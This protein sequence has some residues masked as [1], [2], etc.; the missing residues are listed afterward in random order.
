M[1][2]FEQIVKPSGKF[3]Q[4]D[5]TEIRPT[6][7]I[8]VPLVVIV[9]I[10]L[11]ILFNLVIYPLKLF[12]GIYYATNGFITPTMLAYTLLYL[13]IVIFLILFLAKQK[14]R[15]IGIKKGKIIEGMVVT[16]TIW[17]II[18]IAGLIYSLIAFGSLVFH[19]SLAESGLVLIFTRN[20]EQL[21]FNGPFEELVYRAFLINQVY[22]WYK[23]K[24]ENKSK[25][26]KV[27]EDKPTLN[28]S[29]ISI[30]LPLVFS[31]IV[32]QI[33]FSLMHIPNRIMYVISQESYTSQDILWAAINPVGYG[34]LFIAGL[35]FALIYHRTDN[36]FIASGI[37]ALINYTTLLFDMSWINHLVLWTLI[38]LIVLFYPFLQVKLAVQSIKLKNSSN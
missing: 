24:S 33:I 29:S 30:H 6:K 21:V 27:P 32:T 9:N 5:F 23:L 14:A 37:H 17:A 26:S 22:L 1:N 12:N 10:L 4:F 7:I 20:I 28:V 11:A 3:L 2:R 35:I 38:A 13:I 25:S 31:L 8:F 19:P 16:F 36:I 15:D 34:M 18:Q